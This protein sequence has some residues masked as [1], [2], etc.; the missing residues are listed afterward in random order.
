MARHIIAFANSGGGVLV[1]GVEE[2]EHN[3]LVSCGIEKVIDK[4][5]IN[6]QIEAYIPNEINYEV[7]DFSYSSAEYKDLIGKTFQVMI[8]EYNPRH[9]PFVSRKDGK[10]IR[11]NAIYVR[12]GTSSVI[13]NYRQLQKVLNNRIATNYN[14]SSEMKLEEHLVQLKLLY[15]KI[16][17]FNYIYVRDDNENKESFVYKLGAAVSNIA[18]KLNG[19][20]KAVPNPNYPDEDYEEFISRMIDNKKIRIECLLDL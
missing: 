6:N 2:I 7:I 4:A 11:E 20:R 1:S 9:G 10:N 15:S 3:K 18:T 16:D 13:A 17:K 12:S 14:T 5:N 8:V 19:E